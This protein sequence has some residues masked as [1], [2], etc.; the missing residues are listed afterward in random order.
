[1][2]STLPLS[3]PQGQ[4]RDIIKS[5]TSPGRGM[6][7]SSV[8]AAPVGSKWWKHSPVGADGSA[9][10][11]AEELEWRSCCLACRCGS[12]DAG[13]QFVTRSSCLCASRWRGEPRSPLP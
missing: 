5:S 4:R 11:G 2:Y 6:T 9:P 10:V 12:A 1:M 8:V 3:V 13:I 7:L